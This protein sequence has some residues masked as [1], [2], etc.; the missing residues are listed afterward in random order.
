MALPTNRIKKVKLPGDVNGDK[1][2]EIIPSMLQDGTTSYVAEL[3]E[4]TEDSTVALTTYVEANPSTTTDTLTG[5]KIGDTSYSIASGSTA[6]DV[7]INGTSITSNN[8]ANILTKSAYNASTNK[9][10]TESDL[11]QVKRYI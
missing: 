1:T 9:I 3:P 2:Y 10:V 4:L 6:T 11:T 5:I 7:Q 8:V